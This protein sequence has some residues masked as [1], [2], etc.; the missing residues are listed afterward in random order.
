MVMVSNLVKVIKTEEN[1]VNILDYV[2]FPAS[3]KII[4]LC[5]SCNTLFHFNNLNKLDVT[6]IQAFVKTACVEINEFRCVRKHAIVN[7]PNTPINTG[8]IYRFLL[9]ARLW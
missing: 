5:D 2:S 3:T 1:T 4:Q 8:K 7:A 6:A 9:S